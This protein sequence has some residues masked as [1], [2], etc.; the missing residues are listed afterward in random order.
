MTDRT[1]FKK[2]LFQGFGALAISGCATIT[3]D[4]MGDAAIEASVA[5][6]IDIT[7]YYPDPDDSE[8]STKCGK[9]NDLIHVERYP[10]KKRQLKAEQ[11]GIRNRYVRTH[12]PS[13]VQLRWKSESEIR[14]AIPSGWNP[15][16][17]GDVRWC[18]GTI[19][20]Q[21]T[22][23]TASHCIW[24]LEKGLSGVKTLSDGTKVRGHP[25]WNTP[26]VINN[27]GEK[28]YLKEDE[29]GKLLEIVVGYQEN[30]NGV[31][32]VGTQHAISSVLENGDKRKNGLDYA[33]LR[34]DADFKK[35][36]R[37]QKKKMIA[38]MD[39][40]TL[41][42]ERVVSIIQ[43]PQGQ[44]K[45]I[46]SGRLNDVEDLVIN[47]RDLDT[48]P[49]SSGSGVRNKRGKIVG[50]HTQGGCSTVGGANH[51]VPLSAVKKVSD[52]L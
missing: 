12:E 52:L 43:H 49:G 34:V 46:E 2:F 42:A 17:V 14:A 15:G 16:N 33:V 4:E 22:V 13:T 29:I 40:R 5:N 41:R 11:E 8:F 31:E 3:D 21:N 27:K 7:G 20:S 39:K 44:P 45:Q 30:S 26:F 47:Y 9:D 6:D 48:Y 37:T 18:T 25:S 35:M 10:K 24:I 28:S 38:V 32:Q 1:L 19:I 51:G 36:A 23:L 50:V